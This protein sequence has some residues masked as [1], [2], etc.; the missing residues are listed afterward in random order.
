MLPPFISL[1]E[2]FARVTSYTKEAS[3]IGENF[4][5]DALRRLPDV[6]P[7]RLQSMDD[8]NV[9]RQ[10]VSHVPMVLTLQQASAVNDQL[11]EACRAHPDRFSGFATL[12]MATPEAI[13]AEL[14]RCVQELEFVGT[15][16][17][18]HAYGTFYDGPAYDQLWAAA[19][20]LD[21]PVYLHPA[22]PSQAM[23]DVLYTGSFSATDSTLLG[24]FAYGWHAEV[25]T[26]VL[27]LFAAGVFDRFPRLK[28]IVGHFGSSLPM[29][30]DRVAWSETLGGFK[31]RQR[32]FKAVY[33]ENIWI[34]TSGVWSLD[35]LATI[36]R[37]TKIDHILYS[38]DYPFTS[39]EKGLAFMRSL[40]ESGLVDEE[41]FAMIAYKNAQK[42]LKVEYKGG[43]PFFRLE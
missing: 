2:H 16:V 30:V 13:A 43:A 4:F 14:T 40:Q 8:N 7:L 20:A 39:N 5:A 35:P 25:A 24:T 34:T 17:G 23:K 6:G 41:Q 1:E 33:A 36:L 29:F 28:V 19:E 26:H 31:D 38:V 18:N 21:V 11:A 3:G 27:R 42:L 12:P 10:V 37:N 22:E 9:V 15:L 32:N